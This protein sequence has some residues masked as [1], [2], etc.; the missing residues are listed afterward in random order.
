MEDRLDADGTGWEESLNSC[1]PL[2]A[3]T[4]QLPTIWS[5]PGPAPPQPRLF[6]WPG[7]IYGSQ[8]ATV[9]P[10]GHGVGVPPIPLQP[11]PPS[12]CL[13]LPE[14][15]LSSVHSNGLSASLANS[16]ISHETAWNSAPRTALREGTEVMRKYLG[17]KTLTCPSHPSSIPPFLKPNLLP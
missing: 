15:H 14:G 10:R 9:W 5:Q 1:L 8:A 6:L 2:P 7:E 16:L 13:Q 17:F 3:Q 11:I 4:L 12:L